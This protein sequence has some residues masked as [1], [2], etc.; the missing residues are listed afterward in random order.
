MHPSRKLATVWRARLVVLFFLLFFPLWLLG[1]R[2]PA[3]GA[4][5]I[6]VLAGVCLMLWALIPR[7]CRRLHYHLGK[8]GIAIT[9]GLFFARMVRLP[10]PEALYMCVYRTPFYRL[11][12]LYGIALWGAG[13]HALLPGMTQ[14][15]AQAVSSLLARVE[16][17]GS[18]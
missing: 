18:T 2:N 13:I 8:E 10:Q 14:A 12:G 6:T 4:L 15:Q 1:K 16:Q 17:G 5:A 9:R 3:A 11:A 7:Y